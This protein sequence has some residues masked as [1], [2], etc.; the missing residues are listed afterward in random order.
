MKRAIKTA[1]AVFMVGPAL[2]Q[3]G[4][5]ITLLD[6]KAEPQTYA[7][8]IV[9][10]PGT[11][12]GANRNGA[13]LAAEFEGRGYASVLIRWSDKTTDDFRYAMRECGSVSTEKC[14]VMAT[15]K[16]TEQKYSKG[17]YELTDIKLVFVK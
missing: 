16:V 11:I 14:A 4:Q 7:G 2:S 10:V 17:E 1:L 8:K 9:R 6:L 13:Y 15:G 12:H 5:T 3:D